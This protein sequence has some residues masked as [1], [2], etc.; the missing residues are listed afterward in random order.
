MGNENNFLT[1]AGVRTPVVQTPIGRLW[2]Y[3]CM[4][5]VIP[6]VAQS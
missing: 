1:P 3:C 2:I 4:D 6:E 5:G